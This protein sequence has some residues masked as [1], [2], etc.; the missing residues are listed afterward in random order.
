MKTQLLIVDDEAEIRELLRRHFRYA[1]HEVETAGNG[2]EALERLARVRTDVVVSD[3]QMPEMDGVELLRRV[4]QEYPMTRVIMITGYVSQS[5]ILSC[6]RLGAETCVFKPIE[7]L[8]ELD[9]AVTQAVRTVRR[10]REILGELQGRKS[11]V[12]PGPTHG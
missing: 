10:W 2:V 8:D 6:M 9:A 12:P 3:I 11:V 1:G 7:S 4:R 5:N